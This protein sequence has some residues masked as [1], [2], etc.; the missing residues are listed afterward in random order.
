MY[1]HR[2]SQKQILMTVTGLLMFGSLFFGLSVLVNAQSDDEGPLAPNVPEEVL[3]RQEAARMEFEQRSIFNYRTAYLITAD[4]RQQINTLTPGRVATQAGAIPLTDWDAFLKH[5]E[6]KPFDIVLLHA[7]MYDQVDPDW[8][9]SAYRSNII[10]IG[11]NVPHEQMSALTGDLCLQNPNP[12]PMDVAHGDYIVYYTL[13]IEA[14]YEEDRNAIIQSK[15]QT[16]EDTYVDTAR[17]YA[18][19][20]HGSVQTYLMGSTD[21][22]VTWLVDFLIAETMNYDYSQR[23]EPRN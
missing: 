23:P 16:C 19:V 14:D 11:I 2:F 8:F 6:T 7:S 15:T 22:N 17:G 4:A 1:L 5:H 13:A 10:I 20:I 12:L 9:Y 3:E 18:N 21:E